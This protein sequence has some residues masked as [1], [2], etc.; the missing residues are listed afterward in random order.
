MIA[1]P[2]AAWPQA[3]CEATEACT[4]SFAR[5]IAGIASTVTGDVREH[6]FEQ[7]LARTA[8]AHTL[9]QLPELELAI[10]AELR[11]V[12][13]AILWRRGDELYRGSADAG[14]IML[15]PGL[16][17][18]LDERGSAHVLVDDPAADP[19]EKAALHAQEWCSILRIPLVWHK[20][21]V[22]VLEAYSARDRPWSRFEIRR[23][24]IIAHQLGAALNTIESSPP[25]A[26]LTT[27]GA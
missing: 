15:G 24:R 22:G 14:P 20:R 19:R 21:V 8:K 11:A 3:S 13:V 10:A 6:A 17:A 23:A 25:S 26:R 12:D 27:A 18:A 16:R 5:S 7:I 2:A 4:S 9:A 1:R